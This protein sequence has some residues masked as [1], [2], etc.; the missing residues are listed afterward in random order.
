[1]T[2]LHL[3]PERVVHETIDGETLVIHLATGAYFSL[4]ESGAEIWALL[5]REGSVAGAA[6]ALA[7][8]H[9]AQEAEVVAAVDCLASELLAEDLLVSG[10]GPPSPG[11][12]DVDTP[13]ESA[14]FVGPVL[15]RYT[16]MQ[17][18]L[19]LDPIHEVDAAAGWPAPAPD[20]QP[21][22]SG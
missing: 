7:A 16:D 22:P 2:R 10:P 4:R 6:A 13:P 1:M 3:D 15:E 9:P 18:F 17:Y 19:M 8:R 20:G 14:R 11:R 5:L 21:S 12:P